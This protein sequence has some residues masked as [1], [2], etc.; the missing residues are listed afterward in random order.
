MRWR[1]A[2]PF[3]SLL[4]IVPTLVSAACDGDGI[5]ETGETNQFPP[6]DDCTS[7]YCGNLACDTGLGEDLYGQPT[8][9]QSDCGAPNGQ[10]CTDHGQCVSDACCGAPSGVCVA[11]ISCSPG[12]TEPCSDNPPK[13]PPKIR[14]CNN[15]CSWGSCSQ[16]VQCVEDDDCDDGSANIRQGLIETCNGY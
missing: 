12:S 10:S 1:W 4:L 13:I 16:S 2:L 6:C 5:C 3:F 9:C 8:Y 15:L 14:T 7:A 11:T